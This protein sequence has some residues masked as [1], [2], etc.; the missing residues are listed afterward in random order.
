M[1]IMIS[2]K[3]SKAPSET[4]LSKSQIRKLPELA[5][6]YKKINEHSLREEAYTAC[7]KTYIRLRTGQ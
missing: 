4:K 6:L 1:R 3:K 7:L 2:S 5:Q